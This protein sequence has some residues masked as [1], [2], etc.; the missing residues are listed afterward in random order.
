MNKNKLVLENQLIFGIIVIDVYRIQLEILYQ[1][2][3]VKFNSENIVKE[4]EENPDFEE[5]EEYE[6]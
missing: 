6:R 5:P 3:Q 1:G 2:V 4:F